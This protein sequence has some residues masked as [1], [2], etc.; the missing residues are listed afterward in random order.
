MNKHKFYTVVLLIG[1]GLL[2]A[3]GQKGALYLPAPKNQPAVSIA[4]S[5]AETYNQS[6]DSQDF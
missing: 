5:Q 4:P 2:T 6:N 1:S 3:C